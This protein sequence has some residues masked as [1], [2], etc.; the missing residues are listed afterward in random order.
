[1]NQHV[2]GTKVAERLLTQPEGATM[3]EI[4]VA[5]GGP[6]YNV[7]KSLEAR[8][9]RIRKVKE[10]RETRYFADPPV[11]L[12]LE[13]T[14]T[15]KGQLTIPQEVRKQLRLRSGQAVRF[16]IREGR[17]EISP[18][19]NRLSELAG[20]LPKPKRTITL[21]E[22]DDEIRQS[23]VNRYLRAVGRKPG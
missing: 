12:S 6:Q 23:V 15:S 5:T 2:P 4:I 7:L 20:I 18:V 14:M 11:A 17:A 1:M 8:G 9:Y 19:Y 22:M 13:A 3:A 21:D 16:T 10:G